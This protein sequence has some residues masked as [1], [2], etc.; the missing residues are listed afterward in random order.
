MALHMIQIQ[1]L[2][3]RVLKLPPIF[4]VHDAPGIIDGATWLDIPKLSDVC[5]LRAMADVMLGEEWLGNGPTNSKRKRILDG[6][7]DICKI[8]EKRNDMQCNAM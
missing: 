5:A 2:H 1:Y 4:A 7:P 6:F 3:F 8:A